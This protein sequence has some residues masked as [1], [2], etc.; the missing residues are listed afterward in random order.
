MKLIDPDHPFYAVVWR[1]YAIVATCVIWAGVEL[2]LG[3]PP[4]A[5]LFAA[6]GA[7]SFWVLI[8]TFGK[9]EKDNP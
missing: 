9:S 1:R 5:M 3:S 8:F 4:W 2:Y 6:A 7:Y